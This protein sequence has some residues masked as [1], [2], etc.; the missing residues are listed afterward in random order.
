MSETESHK[1]GQIN[2]GRT[3]RVTIKECKDILNRK[4]SKAIMRGLL[5][6]RVYVLVKDLTYD[7]DKSYQ[8]LLWDFEAYLG[9]KTP[10]RYEQ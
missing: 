4:Y 7:G 9:M 3:F 2:F 6:R 8:E 1:D 10:L 5:K